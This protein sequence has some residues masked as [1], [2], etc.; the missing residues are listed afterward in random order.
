MTRAYTVLQNSLRGSTTAKLSIFGYIVYKGG[1]WRFGELPQR[2]TPLKQSGRREREILQLLKDC[3]LLWK[4]WRKAKDHKKEGLKN[5]WAQIRT[6][7]TNPRRAEII[8]KSRSRRRKQGQAS[9][10]TL[11]CMPE[12]YWRIRRTGRSTPWNR[13]WRTIL[14]RRSVTA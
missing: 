10:V 2:K 4:A 1:K 8:R 12:A 6:R 5:L 11:L 13:S 9:S 14:R 7:L 3:R